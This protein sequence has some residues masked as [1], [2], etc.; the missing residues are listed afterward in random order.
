MSNDPRDVSTFLVGEMT[1]KGHSRLSTVTWFDKS[2]IPS[3]GVRCNHVH[4]R[5]LKVLNVKS[6]VL[7]LSHARCSIRNNLASFFCS[8]LTCVTDFHEWI[9]CCF[10]CS[11]VTGIIHTILSASAGS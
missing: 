4:V 9:E 5:M 6:F 2:C 3:C 8:V 10:V 11:Y 7:A 1:F